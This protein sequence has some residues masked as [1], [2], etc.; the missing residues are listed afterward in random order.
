MPLAHINIH[1]ITPARLQLVHLMD[2]NINSAINVDIRLQSQF[3]LQ[4]IVLAATQSV[5]R[6]HVPCQ[7]KKKVIAADVKNILSAQ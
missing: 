2:L 6:L 7:V 4:D 1:L 5:Y 3:L